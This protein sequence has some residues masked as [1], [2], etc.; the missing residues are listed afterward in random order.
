MY[1]GGLWLPTLVPRLYSLG[2]R[3]V[4]ALQYTYI[5]YRKMT[6]T[7]KILSLELMPTCKYT[8]VLNLAILP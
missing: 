7:L 1:T 4:V 6:I 8:N 3:V 5:M 2:T